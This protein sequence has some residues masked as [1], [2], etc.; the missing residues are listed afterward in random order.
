M[1]LVMLLALQTGWTVVAPAQ[2]APASAVAV[3]PLAPGEVLLEVEETGTVT[4]AG[5]VAKVVIPV[6]VFRPTAQEA[7]KAAAAQAGRIADALRAAGIAP[8]DVLVEEGERVMGFVGNEALTA[9]AEMQAAHPEA[10]PKGVATYTI[11]VQ[12]R[13]PAAFERLRS[14]AEAAGA[15]SVARGAFSLA[16]DSG[17]RH[18]ASADAVRRARMDADAYA[19]TLGMRVGRIVRVTERSGENGD[20]NAQPMFMRMMTG[21]NSLAA[22]KVE[23]SVTVDVDFALVPL[24]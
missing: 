13:D 4:T 6:T 10:A 22:G 15:T 1:R 14:A 8:A 9:N 5:D 23:T 17:A 12:L 2:A 16:D 7:R 18:A 20:G 3:A 24:P 19:K 21:G 11:E